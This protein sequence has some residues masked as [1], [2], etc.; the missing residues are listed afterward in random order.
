MNPLQPVNGDGGQYLDAFVAK[1]SPTG[2]ALVY[3]TYLGGSGYDVGSGIAVD[4]SGNAYVTGQ[5]QS[6]NFPTVNALQPAYGGGTDVFVA[7]LNPTGSALAYSTYLGGSGRDIGNGIA[8][9]SSGNAYVTGGTASTDFPTM[10]P[11]QPAYGG[12]DFDAF[13]AEFNPTGSALIY[14]TYLGGSGEDNGGGVAVD[15]SGN[16]YVTGFTESTNFPTMNPMQPT[17][18]DGG[19]YSDAF[20]AKIASATAVTLAPS[21]LGFGNQP[22]GDCQRSAGINPNQR[23]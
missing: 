14:S 13:V 18:A 19:V 12:G 5:T 15:S 3:S 21:S 23:H 11:F 10:N 2:S 4:S 22:G 16:A 20:L 9:D 7:K 1:L 6:T 8:V 17:E